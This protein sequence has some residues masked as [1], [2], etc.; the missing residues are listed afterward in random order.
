MH[1]QPGSTL[2]AGGL[3]Q[4]HTL[5]VPHA[6]IPPRVGSKDSAQHRPASR[7][8]AGVLHHGG[9]GEKGCSASRS[10]TMLSA[11]GC[12]KNLLQ[13]HRILT[14]IR[15]RC[16][17]LSICPKQSEAAQASGDQ[18]LLP[19]LLPGLLPPLPRSLPMVPGPAA[20]MLATA[21][22]GAAGPSAAA[23]PGEPPQQVEREAAGAMSEDAGVRQSADALP[24]IGSEMAAA[25]LAATSTSCR[26]LTT[27]GSLSG[28]SDVSRGMSWNSWNWGSCGRRAGGSPLPPRQSAVTVTTGHPSP[29]GGPLP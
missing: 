17:S 20:G 22:P 7:V 13:Q 11:T 29:A 21:L 9:R 19:A 16:R 18:Q 25:A 5:A 1:C 4:Q 23:K 6:R 10:G 12:T 8:H 2:R 26:H 3:P 27:G 15:V 28:L 24:H 14:L